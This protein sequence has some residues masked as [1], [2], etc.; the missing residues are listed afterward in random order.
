MNEKFVANFFFRFLG[1][2]MN[3][4]VEWLFKKY[5]EL[6]DAGYYD[7]PNKPKNEPYWFKYGLSK[8]PLFLNFDATKV[9]F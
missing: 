1:F 4:T 3:R 9:I 8:M 7:K 6:K 2:K 5:H